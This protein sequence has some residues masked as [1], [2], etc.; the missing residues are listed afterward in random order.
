MGNLQDALSFTFIWPPVVLV[1]RRADRYLRLSGH[2]IQPSQTSTLQ[3][4][5]NVARCPA[6][7]RRALRV[8]ELPC[9]CQLHVA[10]SWLSFRCQAPLFRRLPAGRR[11]DNRPAR[12]RS[13][14]DWV[15][16]RSTP[17]NRVTL[18]S[19]I[20]PRLF[21]LRSQKRRALVLISPAWGH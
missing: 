11:S 5:L 1:A 2:S 6:K 14:S 3:L 7:P 18:K 20:R 17:M 15:I 12:R 13:R 16:R 9:R 21:C 10:Y 4:K 19:G 8:T